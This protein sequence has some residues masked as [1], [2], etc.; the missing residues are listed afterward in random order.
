[1]PATRK[2]QAGTS[3][4]PSAAGSPGGRH[5]HLGHGRRLRSGA[6]PH[7]P[8]DVGAMAREAV[9]IFLRDASKATADREAVR[10]GVAAADAEAAITAAAG[11]PAGDG[12]SKADGILAAAPEPA[13]MPRDA[14][15]AA[16]RVAGHRSE[17]RRV[18]KER[19]SRWSPY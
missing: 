17:E 19:R 7:G 10:A 4:P 8:P 3:S 6:V 11:N 18:G 16:S 12:A 5:R 1:M 14:I 2:T 13:A 15:S 9:I